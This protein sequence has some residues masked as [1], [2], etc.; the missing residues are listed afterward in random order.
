[1]ENES[2][3]LY[4]GVDWNMFIT[5][6]CLNY[7][8]PL[9]EGVDWNWSVRRGK[10]TGRPVSLFTREWIEIIK[11]SACD[12]STFVSLF[13]REWIEIDGAFCRCFAASGLP[14]YEGVDW[15]P[16]YQWM[17]E[18]PVLSPS[19]RG[20]GLK[21]WCVL[22]LFC[23]VS[24]SLFTREWIEMM[25]RFAVVLLRQRLPLYEGVDWNGWKQAF[26]CYNME[27]SLF[28]REWIEIPAPVPC[29]AVRAVSLFTREWIEI[30][31]FYQ[32]QAYGF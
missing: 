20:S 15:N 6:F 13:T 25:V 5:S 10:R 22:P 32:A 31:P 18:K 23:C 2:L 11:S 4:E 14:L 7:S 16:T 26:P 29:F 8:L 3:P 9:Y 24:V 30:F 27:V 12:S 1:M 19:L 21:W 17:T 28:T